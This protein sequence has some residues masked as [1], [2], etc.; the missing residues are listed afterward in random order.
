M[1]LGGHGAQRIH[2]RLSHRSRIQDPKLSFQLPDRR[3]QKLR[4]RGV[5]AGLCFA[6]GCSERATTGATSMEADIER[7]APV[8]WPVYSIRK[9]CEGGGRTLRFEFVE[10]LLD[11]LFCLLN[12]RKQDR[13]GTNR[14]TRDR[15]CLNGGYAD[16]LRPNTKRAMRGMKLADESP[17][18]F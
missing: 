9:A 4:T 5:C 7:G 18:Q 16:P 14:A 13:V 15:R 11:L 17:L 6:K 8:N 1:A 12:D 2:V 10:S 3:V